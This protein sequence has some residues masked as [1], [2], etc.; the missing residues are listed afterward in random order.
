MVVLEGELHCVA[1]LPDD[2]VDALDHVAHRE[3]HA[4]RLAQLLPQLP[5]R[6]EELPGIHPLARA[7]VYQVAEQLTDL[8]SHQK[9]T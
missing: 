7:L 5:C 9:G 4:V 6:C 8:L 3:V 2:V 1:L